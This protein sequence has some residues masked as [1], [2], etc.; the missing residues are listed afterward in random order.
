LFEGIAYT[1]R[2]A[3]EAFEC[4]LPARFLVA[5]GGAVNALSNSIR[6]SVLNR[7]LHIL[8]AGDVALIGAL[9]HAMT[10][11]EQDTSALSALTTARIVAPNA[12]WLA[13]YNAGYDR[14]IS[15]Q[16]SLGIGTSHA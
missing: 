16:K 10:I 4:P 7:P 5:G 15:I 9:R 6:A 13:P 1:R 12:E 14:F 8:E 2:Q 3:V 11:A